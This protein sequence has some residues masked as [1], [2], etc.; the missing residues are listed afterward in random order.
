MRSASIP[1]RI[2]GPETAQPQS[3]GRDEREAR[4]EAQRP[5]EHVGD[6]IHRV[7]PFRSGW[8]RGRTL[9]GKSGHFVADRRRA[10]GCC[11]SG[12]GDPGTGSA[13]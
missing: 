5:R 2:L 8:V 3:G 11:R 1:V 13:S 6:D 4:G 9:A 7:V 10:T 12:T